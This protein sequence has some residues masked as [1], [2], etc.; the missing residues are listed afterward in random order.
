MPRKLSTEF[1]KVATSGPT[2]DGRTIGPEEIEQMAE[3]YNPEEYTANIWYEHIRYFGNFGKVLKL[4]AEKDSKGRMC[5]FARLA[6]TDELMY[7]NNRGQKLFTSIEIRPNFADSGKAY[8]SGLAVTD[9][10]SSLGT[11]ELQ[12]SRVQNPENY[13]TS[14][15]EISPLEME[16]SEGLLGRLL[17]S[18]GRDSQTTTHETKEPGSDAMDDKQF[19]QLIG[20]IES[21]NEKIEAL[22]SKFSTQSEIETEEE[23]E[24]SEAPQSV[25]IEDFNELKS[26]FDDLKQKFSDALNT[27]KSGTKVPEGSGSTEEE[28]I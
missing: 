21:Q 3:S 22:G 18:F 26:S 27:E 2:I 20:A 15:M 19:N 9:S 25:S 7:L 6:P 10:P 14:P 13:F 5:L 16:D 1:V 11:S 8:L 28:V 12:F 17:K 24:G 23:P 4:K